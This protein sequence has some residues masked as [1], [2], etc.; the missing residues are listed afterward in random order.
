VPS[1]IV[2]DVAPE[3][4]VQPDPQ[5]D[6]PHV[7]VAPVTVGALYLP[8]SQFVQTVDA[9]TPE[10]LPATQ[11]SQ[12]SMLFSPSFAENVPAGQS[13]QSMDTFISVK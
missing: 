13:I 5:L 9:M 1:E 6:P 2:P 3:D 7:R 4:G 10:Y 11:S 12:P 8:D